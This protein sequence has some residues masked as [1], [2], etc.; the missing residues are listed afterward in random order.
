MYCKNCGAQIDPIARFCPTCGFKQGPPSG[1]YTPRG[2][3]DSYGGQQ[4]SSWDSADSSSEKSEKTSMAGFVVT[5]ILCV[6]LSMLLIPLVAVVLGMV[7]LVLY[8]L[9]QNDVGAIRRVAIGIVAGLVG[10]YRIYLIRSGA[11]L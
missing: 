11:L 6:F 8:I 3:G 1:G 10:G 2:P 4:E 5:F 7:L 9:M